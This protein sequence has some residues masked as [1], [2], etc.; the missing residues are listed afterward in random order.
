MS[1]FD[2]PTAFAELKD[3]IKERATTLMSAPT[4]Y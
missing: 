3:R 4:T 2:D 1:H